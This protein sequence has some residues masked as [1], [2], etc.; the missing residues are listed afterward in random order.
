GRNPTFAAGAA[1]PGSGS[2]SPATSSTFAAR[3]STAFRYTGTQDLYLTEPFQ[4]GQFELQDLASQLVGH[5]C[6]PVAGETWWDACAGEGGKT[7]HLADLMQNR[8]LI[9]ASDRSV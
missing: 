7:L 1:D 8:G 5:A 3:L 2:P 6:A 9:W 4:R